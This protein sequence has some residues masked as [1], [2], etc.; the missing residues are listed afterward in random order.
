[1]EPILIIEEL[2]A[3][4]G[5]KTCERSFADIIRASLTQNWTR[6]PFDRIIVGNAALN[7]VTLITKDSTIRDHYEHAYWQ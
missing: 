6:E 2:A 1:M 4:I 5:L 7:G 3:V